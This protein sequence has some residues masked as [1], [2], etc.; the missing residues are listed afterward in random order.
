[1]PV[2]GMKRRAAIALPVLG[3]FGTWPMGSVRAQPSIPRIGFLGSAA[4]PE[5]RERLG[6]FREGLSQAGFIE[7]KN[8][9]IEYWWADG[10]NDRLHAL[11][12]EVVRAKPSIIVV[13]GNTTSL[14]AARAATSTIPIVFRIAADP[15]E[16]GAVASL[17]RPGG[18]ATGVTTLG[19]QVGAKQLELLRDTVP[20]ARSVGLLLNPS[21]QPLAGNQAKHLDLHARSLGIQLRVA[22]A[23]KDAEFEPAF[24]EFERRQVDGVVIGVDTFFNSRNE[25]LAALAMRRKLPA[26]SPYKEFAEAGGLLS[27]GGSIADGSRRAGIHTGRILNGEKPADIPVEQ[28]ARLELAVNLKTAKVLG[29]AIPASVLVRADDVIE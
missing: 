22:A 24:A 21:N 23:T 1:M 6:A 27:Y 3:L 12:A 4:A 10:R 18:N 7:G 13:L 2:G 20:A 9:A 29:I 15:V 16:I 25:R 26:I 19:G 28:V 11:A 8:V 14:I 5:W 17:S